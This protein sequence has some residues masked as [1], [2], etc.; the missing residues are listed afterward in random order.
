MTR[1]QE[2]MTQEFIRRIGREVS[3]KQLGAGDSLRRADGTRYRFGFIRYNVRGSNAGKYMVQ[4]IGYGRDDPRGK[5]QGHDTW[6][7]WYV[8]PSDEDGVRYAVQILESCYDH[9]RT[10][11]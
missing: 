4:A 2:Q 5:F 6:A 1:D 3:P 7:W 10:K 11:P 9:S 8:A